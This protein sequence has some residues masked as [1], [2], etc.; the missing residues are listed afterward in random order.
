VDFTVPASY[1]NACRAL[2]SSDQTSRRQTAH[3]IF[4]VGWFCKTEHMVPRVILEN[5]MTAR[6]EREPDTE[7]L[8]RLVIAAGVVIDAQKNLMGILAVQARGRELSLSPDHGAVHLDSM[9]SFC[10]NEQRSLWQALSGS[11]AMDDP[12]SSDSPEVDRAEA[13]EAEIDEAIAVCGGNVRVA[14]RATLIADAFLQAE[15]ERLSEAVS[16][17]FARGRI[18]RPA[19]RGNGENKAG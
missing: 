17:G 19:K 15:V 9:F 8:N 1:A 6:C 13:L 10:S 4:R 11:S 2:V 7:S 5:R 14:L 12:A 18:R 3:G 16:S